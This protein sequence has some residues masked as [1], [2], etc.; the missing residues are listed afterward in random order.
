MS[1]STKTVVVVG[2]GAV[3]LLL[4]R[5]MASTASSLAAKPSPIPAEGLNGHPYGDAREVQL[6][7]PIGS[8]LASRLGTETRTDGLGAVPSSAIASLRAS[9]FLAHR[10]GRY[11][12]LRRPISPAARDAAASTAPWWQK[13]A[14]I[15]QTTPADPYNLQPLDQQG[16]TVNIATQR[17]QVAKMTGEVSVESYGR[18]ST[19]AEPVPYVEP[20]DPSY[21]ETTTTDYFDKT[22]SSAY[23]PDPGQLVGLRG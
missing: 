4:A 3:L 5:K 6:R 23:N 17:P 18:V 8:T 22:T 10:T 12:D 11:G 21:G 19:P 16:N 9:P 15:N 13:K 7:R 20:G 14:L 1:I 2:V